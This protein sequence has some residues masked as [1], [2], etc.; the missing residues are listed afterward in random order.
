MVEQNRYFIELQPEISDL[1]RAEETVQRRAQAIRFMH[2]IQQWL[3]A[4]NMSSLVSRVA[5][6]AFGQIHITC[7]AEVIQ[8]I[9]STREPAIAAIRSGTRPLSMGM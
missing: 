4:Q 5:V 1:P 9:R 7:A 2:S 6:T 3:A 8:T